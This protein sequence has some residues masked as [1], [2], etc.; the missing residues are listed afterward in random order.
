MYFFIWIIY[1]KIFIGIDIWE[2]LLDY[3]FIIY[4]I[5]LFY[6]KYYIIYV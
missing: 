6:F 2:L 3:G 5:I 1:L 4:K